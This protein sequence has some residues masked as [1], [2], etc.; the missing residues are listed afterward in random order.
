MFLDKLLHD[1]NYDKRQRPGS[2]NQATKVNFSIYVINIPELNFNK[3]NGE[4]TLEMYFRQIWTDPRLAFKE[5]K[6]TNQ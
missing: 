2:Q 5:R 4:M 6:E 3:H 1:S